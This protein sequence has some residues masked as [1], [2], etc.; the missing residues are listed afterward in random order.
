LV[1]FDDE[2]RSA[3][4]KRADAHR[5]AAESF[6]PLTT[7]ELHLQAIHDVPRL[8]R[9]LVTN[10]LDPMND[11]P[12]E[13]AK[14]EWL[15]EIVVGAERQSSETIRVITSAGVDEHRNVTRSRVGLEGAKNIATVGAGEPDVE[16]DDVGA[17]LSGNAQN[18]GTVGESNR[19]Q[20]RALSDATNQSKELGVVFDN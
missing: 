9:S 4:R 14:V 3:R 8:G 16:H 10:L 2:N 13:H 17:L 19:R 7:Q 11:A 5:A 1:V 20:P 12:N 6:L 15:F 18:F